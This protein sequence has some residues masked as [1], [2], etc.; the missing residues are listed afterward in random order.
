MMYI[1]RDSGGMLS[2]FQHKPVW[3][4][5]M[6][7]TYGGL[8]LRVPT[9]WFPDVKKGTLHRIPYAKGKTLKKAGGLQRMGF[10]AAS[11]DYLV[12]GEKKWRRRDD[13][14]RLPY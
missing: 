4:E 12:G 9:K 1:G 8:Y 13:E 5:G 14:L 6:W 7:F 3:A 10:L 2:L 11:S